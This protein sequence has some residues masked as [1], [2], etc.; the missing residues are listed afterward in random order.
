MQYPNY[1]EDN[2]RY[3]EGE[4]IEVEA[5][6]IGFF[7]HRRH[8]PADSAHKRAGEHFFLRP[9]EL[10]KQNGEK[11]LVTAR[12]QLSKHWMKEVSAKEEAAPIAKPRAPKAKAD[13]S[14]I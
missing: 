9:Y 7:D 13:K 12:Q 2:I 14:V 11:V 8:Y 1:H 10:T 5:T 3:V 6:A 4:V